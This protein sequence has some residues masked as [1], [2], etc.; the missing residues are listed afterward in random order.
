MDRI[1]VI[2]VV[3]YK[4][5][6]GLS[7]DLCISAV[8]QALRKCPLLQYFTSDLLLSTFSPCVR[9]LDFLLPP[10][11]QPPVTDPLPSQ[12]LQVISESSSSSPSIYFT[13]QISSAIRRQFQNRQAAVFLMEKM[14]PNAPGINKKKMLD[15]LRE[16]HPE[17][18]FPSNAKREE[19]AKRVRQQQPNCTL[20]SFSQ[21][22]DGVDHARTSRLAVC[23]AVFPNPESEDE[24]HMQVEPEVTPK[25][26]KA[27]SSNALTQ[28][29]APSFRLDALHIGEPDV[30]SEHREKRPA[31]SD[32]INDRKKRLASGRLL[33]CLVLI[34]PCDAE[35]VT[36]LN[37]EGKLQ[38]KVSSKDSNPNRVDILTLLLF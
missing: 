25:V 6:F 19:I 11:S 23:I 26:S 4:L 17:V 2:I 36:H 8:G 30:G 1:T 29:L 20:S 5:L 24:P 14:D 21:V 27:T 10:L 13:S 34:S 12:I 15:W 16:N 35:I 3:F 28:D 31:S 37:F 7:A 22:S 38:T 18:T 32:L 9:L 33:T